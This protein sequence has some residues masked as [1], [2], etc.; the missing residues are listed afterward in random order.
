MGGYWL[1][2]H[3]HVSGPLA[4]VVAGLFIGNE[5]VRASAMS[6]TTSLYVD[7]F[8]ELVDVFLNAVLFV[9]IGLEIILMDWEPKIL[10]LGVLSIPVVLMARFVSLEIPIR[11]MQR[12][13]NFLPR[14]SWIMTW[15]GLRGGISIA[16]ALSLS[17]EMPRELFLNITYIIVLF[18]IVVQGLTVEK[19]VGLVGVGRKR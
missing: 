2:S 19:V 7:K 5:T 16:L 4:M 6:A 10:L 17:A 15:G 9:L 3:W 13:L 8:W 11:F 1:A 18:S 14:T 12:K